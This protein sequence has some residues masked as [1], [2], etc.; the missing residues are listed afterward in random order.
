MIL[1]IFRSHQFKFYAIF[2]I[3][4]LLKQAWA[5]VPTQSP[6]ELSSRD[7]SQFY[8]HVSDRV[9][10]EYVEP[11]S[12]AHLLEGALNGMLTSLDPHSAYLNPDKF[13]EVLKQT[14]GKFAG[15]GLEIIQADGLIKVV[16][17]IEDSP[18]YKAGMQTGDIIVSIDKHPVL[19]MSNVDVA[20]RMRGTPGTEV[21]ITIRRHNQPPFT[22][23]LKREVINTK[24]VKWRLEGNI[25]YLRITLFSQATGSD[26]KNAIRK[27]QESLGEN[28]LGFVLDLR[29]NTGGLFDQA[30]EVSDVFLDE[31]DI[32][33]IKGRDLE[34]SSN[35]KASE[36]DLVNRLPVV[37]LI[38][39]GSASASEI[40][41][42]ALQ[43]HKRALIVGT[44]SF[45][46]GSVQT[47]YPLTNGGAIKLTTALYY[48]PLGRSIQKSGITP[49]ITVEQ[50]LNLKM[51]KD[52]DQ[53]RES[54]IVGAIQAPA[55]SPEELQALSLIQ[56]SPKQDQKIPKNET[57]PSPDYQ[58]LQALNIL[59]A[60]SIYKTQ[61]SRKN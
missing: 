13:D 47:V 7:A 58:L 57:K 44:R 25:G 29:N 54:N 6:R 39:G 17:P 34:K 50:Q 53:V 37:V 35:F 10:R 45:G 33:S 26:L 32:V 2:L 18:A 19:N 46:K 31:V 15:V 1:K 61:F 55:P 49:D 42:G 36:G 52:D 12:N 16:S 11:V 48:T 3:I 38:N 43:D 4:L 14:Q 41:A 23:T 28:L 56:S 51:V 30:I 20:K 5:I 60:S 24:P 40:V 9:R 21:S 22:L 59:R 8:N 27:I